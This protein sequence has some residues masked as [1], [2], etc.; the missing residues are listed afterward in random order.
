MKKIFDTK[1]SRPF[2][3]GL[4]IFFAMMSILRFYKTGDEFLLWSGLI[5][6]IGHI[7]VILRIALKTTK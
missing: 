1:N 2:I 6:G 7:V 5:I 3:S 4:W